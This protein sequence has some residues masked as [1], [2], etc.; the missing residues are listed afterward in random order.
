MTKNKDNLFC[1]QIKFSS[2]K[3]KIKTISAFVSINIIIYYL[4]CKSLKPLYLT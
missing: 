2:I 3:P 4:I 1:L